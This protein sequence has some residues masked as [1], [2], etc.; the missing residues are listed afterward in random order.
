MLPNFL[1]V[2]AAKS[3]TTSL[4]KYLEQHPE[5]YMSPVKEPYF[6]SFVSEPPQFA[7]PFDEKVNA[8]IVT[9][10]TDYERL[11][12]G[13]REEQAVGECSNAYLYFPQSAQ[14]IKRYIPGCR[15]LIMLRDPV[16][17]A[18][19]HYLQHVM[20]GTEPLSFEDALVAEEQRRRQSWRWHYHYIAQGKYH[21]QVQ[22]YYE[23][24]GRDQVQVY[25]F[26]EAKERPLVLMRSIC[27][28]LG[29]DVA[30]DGYTFA[31]HNPTGAARKGWLYDFI[32]RP[33]FIKKMTR[34]FTSAA[35]R[36]KLFGAIKQHLDTSHAFTEAPA[37]LPETHERLRDL[38]REDCLKLQDLIRRDLSHWA[39]LARCQPPVAQGDGGA[40]APER[41]L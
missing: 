13:V 8:A 41:R 35:L 27:R 33:N 34:P 39:P 31:V 16:E 38:Y 7:G 22:R 6:F 15:I 30:F 19:S 32:S 4:Y 18:Y 40:Y 26:E 17:R 20:L 10:L 12:E 5:V 3:A 36:M 24:F 11:F 2:G 1:V 28:F 9:S 14:N 37:M 25:L 21:K 29:V 23:V